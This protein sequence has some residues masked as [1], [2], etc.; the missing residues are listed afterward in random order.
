MPIHADRQQ[1]SGLWTVVT[2]APALSNICTGWAQTAGFEIVTENGATTLRPQDRNRG[3]YQILVRRHGR[4]ELIET[5]QDGSS[6]SALFAADMEVLEHYLMAILGDEIRDQ[7]D[8]EYLELPWAA[9]ALHP[10]FTLSAVEN[11]YQT[12]RRLDGSPVA[13]ARCEAGNTA[14]SLAL[15][16][17]LSHLLTF[18]LPT[19]KR[20]FLDVVGAPLLANGRYAAIADHRRR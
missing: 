6:T 9:D 19:L 16:V 2:P 20:A 14:V 3:S 12:L 5:D 11:G 4:L 10:Q 17:P 8:L 18:D 7:L 13:A 1:V 15:L